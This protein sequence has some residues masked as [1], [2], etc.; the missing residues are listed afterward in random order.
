MP[1]W[2]A[3]RSLVRRLRLP[4]QTGN[5]GTVRINV[6]LAEIQHKPLHRRSPVGDHPA[7]FDALKV[8]IEQL[9]AEVTKLET[10]KSAIEAI[11]AGHRADFERERDRRNDAHQSCHCFVAVGGV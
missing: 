6:D 3:A 11:A 8:R 7:D 10:E 9:Q 2:E 1:L 4:R 5:D